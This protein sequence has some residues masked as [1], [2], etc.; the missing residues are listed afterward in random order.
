MIVI[1]V[2]A[3]YDIDGHFGINLNFQAHIHMEYHYGVAGKG[4]HGQG[5]GQFQNTL[6]HLHNTYFRCCYSCCLQYSLPHPILLLLLA[7]YK[8]RGARILQNYIDQK[9]L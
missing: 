8:H 7:I 5:H 4:R 3:G 2:T 6:L 1:A 9:V